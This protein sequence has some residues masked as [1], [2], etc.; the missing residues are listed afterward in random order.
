MRTTLVDD[1]QVKFETLR[2]IDQ[3]ANGTR[4]ILAED[5]QTNSFTML[6]LRCLGGLDV[7]PQV[8][9]ILITSP[10]IDFNPLQP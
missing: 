9:Q 10:V 3:Q 2:R 8:A 4:L 6:S 1:I 5:I 7:C